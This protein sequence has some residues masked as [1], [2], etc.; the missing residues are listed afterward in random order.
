MFGLPQNRARC[1]NFACR[2]G[3]TLPSYPTPTHAFRDVHV[4]M[5]SLDSQFL[6]VTA[7]LETEL[8]PEMCLRD[9]FFDLKDVLSEEVVRDTYRSLGK[10]VDTKTHVPLKDT[11]VELYGD[12]H[13]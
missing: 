12:P 4:S 1:I 10:N 13:I 7:P 11:K 3:L 2:K 8:R 5:N 6:R 9:A